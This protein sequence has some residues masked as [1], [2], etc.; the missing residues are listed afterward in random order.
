MWVLLPCYEPLF[1]AAVRQRAER[2]LELLGVNVPNE[3]DRLTRR[4]DEGK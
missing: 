3:L 2:K 1:D 4:L